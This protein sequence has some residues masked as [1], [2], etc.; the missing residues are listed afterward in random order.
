M[1]GVYVTF[2]PGNP[3]AKGPWAG[4]RN[5]VQ[6]ACLLVGTVQ[7]AAHRPSQTDALG[8]ATRSK[9][10]QQHAARAREP[11]LLAP[12]LPV[13][14]HNVPTRSSSSLRLGGKSQ[15]RVGTC[16]AAALDCVSHTGDS[17]SANA[18][19]SYY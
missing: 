3:N 14:A 9:Q 10:S 19:R 8:P 18:C 16:K 11:W 4:V 5:P 15:R 2:P 1:D 13:S 6:S 12:S 7:G 17:V